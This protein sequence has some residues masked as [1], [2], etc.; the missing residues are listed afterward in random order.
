MFLSDLISKLEKFRKEN[1]D[2]IEIEFQSVDC[3]GFSIWHKDFVIESIER[4]LY[5]LAGIDDI[6]VCPG[7]CE[8][9]GIIQDCYHIKNRYYCVKCG[10]FIIEHNLYDEY[11]YDFNDI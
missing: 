5:A 2:D 10:A 8:W 7:G 11:S 3:T 1:G 4:N 6:I 9:E